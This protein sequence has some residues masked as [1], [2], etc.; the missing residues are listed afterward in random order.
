M[1]FVQINAVS[2]LS[3]TFYFSFATCYFLY[4]C[5]VFLS[6]NSPLASFLIIKTWLFEL[7]L[8]FFLSHYGFIYHL[9]QRK[10]SFPPLFVFTSRH[11]RRFTEICLPSFHLALFN[12]I[13]Q[14]PTLS[15]SYV[16]P[17]LTVAL[18]F[19]LYLTLLL[20]CVS[21]TSEMC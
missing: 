17:F 12:Q 5:F 10:I 15:F 20:F 8:F 16:K 1:R 2:G 18:P 6:L 7:S 4:Y 11:L 14:F 13:F 19:P 21:D 9:F 3:P